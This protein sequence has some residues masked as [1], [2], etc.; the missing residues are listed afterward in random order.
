MYLINQWKLTGQRAPKGDL[1]NRAY[2]PVKGLK[3][4]IML[5]FEKAFEGFSHYLQLYV[6][7]T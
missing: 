4:F 5:K 1:L 7:E 6:T 2:C 3:L